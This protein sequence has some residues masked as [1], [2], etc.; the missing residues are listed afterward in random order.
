M[1]ALLTL[2]SKNKLHMNIHSQPTP[3][4]SSFLVRSCPPD[5]TERRKARISLPGVSLQQVPSHRSL[6]SHCRIRAHLNSSGDS[7]AGAGLGVTDMECKCFLMDIDIFPSEKY[8]SSHQLHFSTTVL[9]KTY[10][11]R[12][13]VALPF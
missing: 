1:T 3:F 2:G 13:N 7:S 10:T 6:P 5:P 9:P 8:P 11:C 12:M 4:S